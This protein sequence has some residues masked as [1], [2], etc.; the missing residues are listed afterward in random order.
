M[1][2]KKPRTFWIFSCLLHFANF[3]RRKSLILGL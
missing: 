2:S 3:Y 1:F